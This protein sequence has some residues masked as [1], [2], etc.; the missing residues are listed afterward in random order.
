[1]ARQ[2]E[3]PKVTQIVARV[4]HVDHVVAVEVNQ[5]RCCQAIVFGIAC[6]RSV[7][8]SWD[9]QQFTCAV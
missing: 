9:T 8:R 7:S 1:M 5:A 6:T 3:F 2:I 4:H